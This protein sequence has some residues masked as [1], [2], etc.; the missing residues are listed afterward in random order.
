V[1]GDLRADAAASSDSEHERLRASATGSRRR[2]SS[3]RERIPT[4][5]RRI[6][7][8]RGQASG[9]AVGGRRILSGAARRSAAADG[10]EGEVRRGGGGGG[11]GSSEAAQR[12]WIRSSLERIGRGRRSTG[13]VGGGELRPRPPRWPSTSPVAGASPPCSV[14]TA[15]HGERGWRRLA[16]RSSQRGCPLPAPSTGG[17]RSS[18]SQRSRL[19]AE[20][21]VGDEDAVGSGRAGPTLADSGR[22]GNPLNLADE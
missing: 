12:R 18:L 17:R 3:A 10:R 2:G 19:A 7:T 14:S 22:T 8:A 15:V 6:P 11:R 21:G 9:S 1:R 20:V 16:G 13:L 4:A 5:T